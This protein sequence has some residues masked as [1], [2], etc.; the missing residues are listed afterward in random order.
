VQLAEAFRLVLRTEIL[1]FV[2][3]PGILWLVLRDR[4]LRLPAVYLI[5][6]TFTTLTMGK[7]G[8]AENHMLQVTLAA[9]LASAIVY[10][11]MRRGVTHDA[12]FAAITIALA[13]VAIVN[14]PLPLSR[15]LEKVAECGPATSAIANNFGDRILSENIG[16]LVTARKPVYISDPFIYRWLVNGAGWSDAPVRKLVESHYFTAIVTETP[17][18]KNGTIDERWPAGLRGTIRQHYQLSAKFACR[19]ANYIYT[20]NGSPAR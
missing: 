4:A 14:T 20:P 8:A 13:S 17:I 18:E 1:P 15:G 19:D 11:R 2:L 12:A 7:I 16:A 6:T 10:D 3:A 9:C 5:F